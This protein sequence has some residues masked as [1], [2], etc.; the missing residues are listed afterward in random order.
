M[1]HATTTSASLS[2][3]LQR[4]NRFSTMLP[5]CFEN[6]SRKALVMSHCVRLN[7]TGTVLEDWAPPVSLALCVE[8][9]TTVGTVVRFVTLVV[10]SGSGSGLDGGCL[11][12]GT[13]GCPAIRE[14]R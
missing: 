6:P 7:L 8:E 1:S 14:H 5:V 3:I 4:C 13:V 9:F 11:H 2:Q 10:L 12:S